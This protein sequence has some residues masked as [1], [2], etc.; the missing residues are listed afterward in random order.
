MP[1]AAQMMPAS[2]AR[3]ELEVL[4][5]APKEKV[6]T[7]LSTD[8]DGWWASGLRCVS[9]D[10]RM[11]A[12]L[13]AGGTVVEEDDSGAG[14]LWFHV[15]QVSP[16]DSVNLAGAIAPPWGGPLGA[17]LHIQLEEEGS[18]TRVKVT[19]SMHGHVDESSLPEIEGGW[20]YLFEEGLKPY[21]ETGERA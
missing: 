19:N 16:G 9:P 6:W 17:F 4:I 20:R 21:V 5:E 3:L 13:R 18:N 11:K 7:T 2:A 12:D 14:I 8:F 1:T 10:S 15:I